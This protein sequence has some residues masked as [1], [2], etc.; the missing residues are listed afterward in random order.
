MPAGSSDYATVAQIIQADLA[1]LNIQVNVKPLETA[2]FNQTGLSKQGFGLIQDGSLFAQLLPS[3]IT[4]LSSFYQ[5][6]A[7][8]TGLVSESYAQLVN[9]LSVE[10]DPAKQK[11]LYD[12]LN[13]FLIDQSHIMPLVAT[14][15]GVLARS[16]VNGVAWMSHEGLDMRSAWL[17]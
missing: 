2:A 3:A 5:P 8:K 7:P 14:V 16:N 11:A 4:V 17:G 15:P 9:A 6:S 1:K 10:L 13:D 12:Q